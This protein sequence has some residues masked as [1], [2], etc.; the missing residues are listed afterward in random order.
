MTATHKFPMSTVS[1][2]LTTSAQPPS[3]IATASITNM[4][5]TPPMTTTDTLPLHLRLTPP[6]LEA[7]IPVA[8]RDPT[9]A[10]IATASG[11]SVNVF[12]KP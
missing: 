12:Q 7:N 8:G 1:F 9:N 5:T 3:I 11:T 6:A 10:R 4:L 2:D